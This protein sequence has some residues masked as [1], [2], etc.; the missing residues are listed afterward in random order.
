MDYETWQDLQAE[1]QRERDLDNEF[2]RYCQMRGEDL[3]LN[4][5]F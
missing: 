3:W 1:R 4:L 2:D 5:K